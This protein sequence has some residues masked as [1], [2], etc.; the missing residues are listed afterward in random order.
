MI[1]IFNLTYFVLEEC[2]AKLNVGVTKCDICQIQ[3][4]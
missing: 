2:N 4:Y 3:M 1:S